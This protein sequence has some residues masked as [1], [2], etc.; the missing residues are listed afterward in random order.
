MKKV[1]TAKQMERHI[2][3]VSNHYRI[4]ILLA[5]SARENI[6]L[7]DLVERLNASQ[8]TLSEHTR[9]LAQA[10]LITKKYRGRFVEHTLSP[11]GRIFVAFLKS[12]QTQ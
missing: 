6:T 3:G 9:R 7:D 1:K 4:E 2:K 10:G 12:L 11:Y 5:V 8:K